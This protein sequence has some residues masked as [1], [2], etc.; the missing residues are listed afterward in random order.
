M[1]LENSVPVVTVA[2]ELRIQRSSKLLLHYVTH[3]QLRVTEF[4]ILLKNC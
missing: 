3:T 2:I 4:W 1:I